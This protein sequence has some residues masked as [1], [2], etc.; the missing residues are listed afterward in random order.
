MKTAK[1]EEKR[2][3]DNTDIIKDDRLEQLLT[4]FLN[5]TIEEKKT[6]INISPTSDTKGIV[7]L[8]SSS[9]QD[10]L[11]IFLSTAVLNATDIYGICLIIKEKVNETN[12][13]FTFEYENKLYDVGVNFMDNPVGE[14]VIMRIF[15]EN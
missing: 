12:G 7:V 13:R 10:K 4:T 1:L 6:Y 9:S 14:E 2:G 8:S 5:D 11:P 15:Y 3:Q